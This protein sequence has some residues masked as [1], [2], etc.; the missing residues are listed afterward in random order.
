VP[1]TWAYVALGH[2]HQ[3]QPLMGLPH[4]RYSGSIERLD[5]G[6]HRDDKGAVLVEVGPE[7]RRG[8]PIILPIDATPIYDVGIRNPQD[9]LPRLRDLYPH[10]ERALVR[11]RV[12][13]TAGVDNLDAILREL[14]AIFPRWYDRSWAES[15]ELGD[16]S[17]PDD[18]LPRHASLHETVLNYLKAELADHRDREDIL[19]LAEILLAEEAP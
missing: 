12:T 13:Y 5:L 2:I 6:E 9:D 14:D 17:T 19:K 16:A 15:A 3:A 11:Y 7:G 8:E 4:V 18:D 1:T 10:A